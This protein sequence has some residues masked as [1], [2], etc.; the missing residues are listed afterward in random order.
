M[1]A[2]FEN[3]SSLGTYPLEAGV[4]F[5]SIRNEFRSTDSTSV[6]ILGQ[7]ATASTCPSQPLREAVA[8][9]LLAIHTTQALP[10]LA[11]LLD[12]PNPALRGE[13][14]GGLGSFANGLP[15]QTSAGAPSLAHL[16]RPP[17]GPYMTKTTVANFAL[18]PAAAAD[19]NRLSFWK[20]WWLENR[21]S[22]GY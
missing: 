19:D 5:N 12:D 11:A 9:A 1:S 20:A 18:G 4:L 16:Q 17:S 7:I 6:K 2:A 14:I 15:V 22:L 13:G 21:A 8:H 3:A 10:Y